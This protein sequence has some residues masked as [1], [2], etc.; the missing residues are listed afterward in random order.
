MCRA[1]CQTGHQWAVRGQA[2]NPATAKAAATYRR[3]QGGGGGQPQP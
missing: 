3:S 1:L 2:W